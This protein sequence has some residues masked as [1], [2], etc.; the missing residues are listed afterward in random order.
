M[1]RP[2]WK[3]SSFHES[4]FVEANGV[5]IN[6]LDW[7]GR[8]DPLVLVHGF[9]DNPHAFDDLAPALADRF[10]VISYARRAHG[11]SETK[12]PYD[13]ATLVE[14]LR[15]LLRH[16][17]IPSA[18][19][20]GWSMGGNEITAMAALHPEYVNRIVYLDAAFDWFDPAFDQVVR[21]FPLPGRPPASAMESWPAYLDWHHRMLYPSLQ[22]VSRV[23]AYLRQLAVDQPDGS[24]KM[25]MN[26]EAG[27]AL[28]KGLLEDRKEYSRVRC[29][30]L[31][32]YAATCGDGE[33]GDPELCSKFRTYEE[34]TFSPF[35][36]LSKKRVE[37]ELSDLETLTLPGT[38]T[39]FVY[40]SRAKL[41][42]E[43]TRF[44]SG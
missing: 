34:H 36:E 22:N 41:V 3:D 37:A 26:S 4:R 12:P 23:E 32:V 14:D 15:A 10:R 16:L 29:P 24:I 25:R 11:L 19:L 20:A 33:N 8:G 31:A 21:E 40:V 7:G 6:Y 27:S 28:W 1:T 38:H 35:R 30:A 2:P 43:L 42:G 18:H 13:T 17:K 39:D 9:G 44:L 5:R